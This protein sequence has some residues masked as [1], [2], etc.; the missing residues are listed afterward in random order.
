MTNI[1]SRTV[2]DFGREWSTYDQSPMSHD[3]LERQF[4]QYF[5]VFP[6]ATL[7][8]D[9]QG[10]DAGCGS[11][12]WAQLVAPRVGKLH[13]V[14]ASHAALAVARQKLAAMPNCEFHEAS[15]DEMPFENGSMDFGYSLG[16]LH[17]IP[18]TAAGIS[19]CIDKL[20]PGAPFLIYLYY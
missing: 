4:S 9:A 11:G 17:H 2:A 19:A 3:E 14:D 6:W 5:A 8:A 13:C 12:R 1:D 10:F 18:N 20:K 16:V 15:V 7:R